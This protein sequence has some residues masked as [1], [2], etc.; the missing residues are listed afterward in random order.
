MLSA[1]ILVCCIGAVG[2]FLVAYCR[3]L[4]AGCDAHILSERARQIAGLHGE[5]LDPSEFHRLLGLA[6]MTGMPAA[7]TGQIHAVKSY[8]RVLCLAE[9]LLPSHFPRALQW[10]HGEL[11]RCTYFAAVMLDRRLVP[12]D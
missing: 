5:T 8:Y 9:R 3:T 2:Q 4:L 10:T 1:I 6:R 11:S 7:D 12:A